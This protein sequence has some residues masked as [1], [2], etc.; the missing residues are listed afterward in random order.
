MIADEPDLVEEYLNIGVCSL[1]VG[2]WGVDTWP[3][4][5]MFFIYCDQ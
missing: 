4:S 5:K 1:S 2:P 3:T